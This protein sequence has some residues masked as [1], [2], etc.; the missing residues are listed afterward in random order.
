MGEEKD[1]SLVV[2]KK[3]KEKVLCLPYSKLFEQYHRI[4]LYIKI[5]PPKNAT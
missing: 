5:H 2:L 3:K 4:K 1:T